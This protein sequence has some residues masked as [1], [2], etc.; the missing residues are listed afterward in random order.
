MATL[1]ITEY[2]DV[3]YAGNTEAANDIPQEPA[4]AEQTVAI[5]ASSTQSSAFKNNTRLVRIATDAICSIKFGTSPTATAASYRLA[6]NTER[7]IGVPMG[8]SYKVAVITNT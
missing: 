5:G 4:N 2:A 7:Y 6:A 1:Y 3:A 8:A